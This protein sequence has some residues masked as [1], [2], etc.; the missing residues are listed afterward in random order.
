MMLTQIPV[1][2][3]MAW[4]STNTALGASDWSN[5]IRADMPAV[6]ALSA[7]PSWAD[8]RNRGDISGIQLQS[9]ISM[10]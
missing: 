7:T 8:E 5:T 4:V 2:A 1:A 6:L 10:R 3:I 9:L